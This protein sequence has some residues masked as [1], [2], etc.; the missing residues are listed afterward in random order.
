MSDKSILKHASEGVALGTL[1]FYAGNV[2]AHR[3]MAHRTVKLHPVI[4][5]ACR[6]IFFGVTGQDSREFSVL[7]RWHHAYADTPKDQLSPNNR[8]TPVAFV[9]NGFDRL[10]AQRNVDK[11]MQDKKAMCFAAIDT[12]PAL[13]EKTDGSLGLRSHRMNKLLRKGPLGPAL[14]F[15]A[16]CAV[17][18]PKTASIIIVGAMA[19][20]ALESAYLNANG[21]GKG[22]KPY[23]EHAGS[24]GSIL[25]SI[26]SGGDRDQ[27]THHAQP[28]NPRSADPSH[29]DLTFALIT[30]LERV[31]LATT[32]V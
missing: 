28:W 27:N 26:I 7:H 24:D 12:D 25:G 10:K 30:A 15:G 23:P 3:E 20:P 4:R 19:V 22:S 2:H 31:G 32:K 6:F 8:S 9:M 18:G 21:H 29:P 11:M 16:V 17:K 13:E 1:A 5:E 14:L